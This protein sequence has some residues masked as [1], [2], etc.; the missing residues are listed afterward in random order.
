MS[1]FAKYHQELRLKQNHINNLFPSHKVTEIIPSPKV[2]RYRNK[3]NVSIGYNQ[4]GDIEIGSMLKKKII[5]NPKD[6]F[7]LSGIALKIILFTKKWIIENSK[8]KPVEYPSLNHFWRHL[9]IYNTQTN[10]LIHEQTLHVTQLQNEYR[11]RQSCRT[12][13]KNIYMYVSKAH[14]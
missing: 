4:D 5:S 3:I 11:Q 13:N 8:L 9:T 7:Q 6:N 14:K 10:L 1:L 2:Y 12:K